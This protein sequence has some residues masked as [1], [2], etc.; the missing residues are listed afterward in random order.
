MPTTTPI[1]SHRPQL[2]LAPDRSSGAIHSAKSSPASR[3]WPAI[4]MRVVAESGRN[5]AGGFLSM[6]G[7]TFPSLFDLLFLSGLKFFEKQ[8]HIAVCFGHCFPAVP[9]AGR[10][11]NRNAGSYRHSPSGGFPSITSPTHFIV[12]QVIK[13]AVAFSCGAAHGILAKSLVAG[14]NSSVGHAQ[15]FHAL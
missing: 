1:A 15:F 3:T 8:K 12:G 2:A 14:D 5:K 7:M 6:F 13:N 9:K 11:G 4:L 10:V